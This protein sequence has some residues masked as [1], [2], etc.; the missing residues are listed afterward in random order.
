MRNHSVLSKQNKCISSNIHNLQKK[1][2]QTTKPDWTRF[3]LNVNQNR[4]HVELFLVEYYFFFFKDVLSVVETTWL[5][6]PSANANV[7]RQPWSASV[8][9]LVLRPVGRFL[10][11]SGTK[12]IK[13]WTHSHKK[14]F[15]FLF[16]SFR[17][18]WLLFIYKFTYS[19]T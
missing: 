6:D 13:H 15:Y 7:L 8:R 19:F 14:H 10:P 4:G 2:K 9:A 11:T 18:L 16:L 12:F 17:F 1:K 3:V 5:D